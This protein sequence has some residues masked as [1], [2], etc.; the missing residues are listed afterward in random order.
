MILI[1][2]DADFDGVKIGAATHE[3]ISKK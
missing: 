3:G 1:F 2:I